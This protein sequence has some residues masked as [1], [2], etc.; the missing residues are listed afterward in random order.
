[1]QKFKKNS[2][3]IKRSVPWWDMGLQIMRSRLRAHRRRFQKEKEPEMKTKYMIE[4]K[5]LQNIYKKGIVEA[6]KKDF[7]DFLEKVTTISTFGSAYK[8]VRNYNTNNM[9]LNGIKRRDETYTENILDARKKIL[10]Q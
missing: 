7:K 8:I 10:L 1:M 9:I 4:F 5:R 6:K 2:K 3:K